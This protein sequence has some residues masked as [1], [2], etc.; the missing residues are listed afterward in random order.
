M[1]EC[2]KLRSSTTDMN[3]VNSTI[4]CCYLLLRLGGDVRCMFKEFYGCQ[5][6]HDAFGIFLLSILCCDGG[7]KGARKIRSKRYGA[8]KREDRPHQKRAPITH[9]LLSTIMASPQLA[10]YINAVSLVSSIAA[11]SSSSSA[12]NLIICHLEEGEVEEEAAA[13]A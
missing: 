3:S 13:G 6:L 7:E 2:L 12:T 1:K 5:L 4:S 11:A 9:Q 10:P 8:I